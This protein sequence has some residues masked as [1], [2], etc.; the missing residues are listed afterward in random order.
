MTT[1]AKHK[2]AELRMTSTQHSVSLRI[3]LSCF[4][5]MKGYEN[6]CKSHPF[7]QALKFI[8]DVCCPRRILLG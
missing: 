7:V 6:R 8:S 3:K 2:S 4:G 5:F 1:L